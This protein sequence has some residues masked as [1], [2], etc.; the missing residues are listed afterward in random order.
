MLLILL[1]QS[2]KVG[3]SMT[4]LAKGKIILTE[5]K[6]VENGESLQRSPCVTGIC[7]EPYRIESIKTTL[8]LLIN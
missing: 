6:V 3:P 1:L 2:G 7:G 5:E 8:I 4:K